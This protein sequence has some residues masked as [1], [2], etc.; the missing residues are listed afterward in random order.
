MYKPEGFF[1]FSQINFKETK[2]KFLALFTHPHAIPNLYDFLF[3]VKNKRSVHFHFS[4]QV[5]H[6]NHMDFHGVFFYIVEA[7]FGQKLSA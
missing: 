5:R 2:I 4:K 7:L 1:F 3:F 6:V